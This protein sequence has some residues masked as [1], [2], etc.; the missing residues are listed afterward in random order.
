[1]ENGGVGGE[2]DAN[3]GN[4][5]VKGRKSLKS[6]E[7]IGKRNKGEEKEGENIQMY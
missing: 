4:V 3:K 1:V 2:I 6:K 7:I 5:R